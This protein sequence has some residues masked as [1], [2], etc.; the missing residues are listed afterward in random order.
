MHI[1]VYISQMLP[2]KALE[3]LFSD[4]AMNLMQ[5]LIAA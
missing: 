5:W 3:A 2:G 4:P 1:A